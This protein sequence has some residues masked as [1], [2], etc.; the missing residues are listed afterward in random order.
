MRRWTAWMLSLTAAC[1]M[2]AGAAGAFQFKD[3]EGK[4]SARF[5]AEPSLDRQDGS[6]VLGPHVHTTWEV[7]VEDRHW[8]VTYTEYSRPPVKNYDKNVMGLLAATNGKL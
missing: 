4:F 1:L 8:S 6:S 5:P 2:L 7:D 3:E